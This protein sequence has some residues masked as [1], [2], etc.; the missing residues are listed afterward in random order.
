[1]SPARGRLALRALAGALLATVLLSW[2][3][4]TM[5]D[6]LDQV[7]RHAWSVRPGLLA[8]SCIPLGVAYGLWIV[9][10][11]Q[12][13]AELGTRLDARTAARVWLVSQLGKYVPGKIWGALGRVALVARS[14][15]QGLAVGLSILYEMVLFLVSGMLVSVAALPASALG[16]TWP[17]GAA[18]LL[19][20]AALV[21]LLVPATGRVLGRCAARLVPGAG[22]LRWATI[23]PARLLALLLGYGASWLAVGTGFALFV[24]SFHSIEP[25]ALVRVALGFVLAWAAGT[26][27][28]LAP[29]G[30]GVREAALLV[31]LDG[32]VPRD[33]ALVVVVAS[34]LWTTGLELAGLLGAVAWSG[35]QAAGGDT[36][37]SARA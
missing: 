8:A 13:L 7:S 15:A 1:M 19:G 14:P 35:G 20:A 9:L 33:V 18:A 22:Q 23:R 6:D 28:F 36:D 17:A 26:V 27:V 25:R 37:A 5:R 4:Y 21:A 31:Y 34:R 29:A 10:W 32:L 3:A 24:A 2:I 11:R 16:G 12:A 30:L